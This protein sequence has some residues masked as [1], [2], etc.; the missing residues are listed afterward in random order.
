[1]KSAEDTAAITTTEPEVSTQSLDNARQRTNAPYNDRAWDGIKE[2]GDDDRALLRWFHLYALDNGLSNVQ[3]GEIVGYDRTNAYRILMGTY[4]GGRAW[5]KIV[6]A[7]RDYRVRALESISVPGIDK[8]PGF[9]LTS[10]ATVFWNGLDYASR[11]GF[12]LLAGPSGAGKSK[13]AVEWDL[14]N[15]GRAVRFNAP[16]TGAH[17]SLI[18]DLAHRIGLGAHSKVSTGTLMRGLLARVGRNQVLIVDQGSRLLPN[19]EQ[20]RATSLEILMELNE[21]TGCGVVIPLTWRSVESMAHMAYQIEQITGRAEI[22]RAPDPTP[23]DIT[24]IA[25]QYGTF[26]QRIKAALLDLSHKPGGL[27]TVSKVLSL[28]DRMARAVKSP[29]V[30][31]DHVRAAMEKRFENMGGIDPF[32]TKPKRR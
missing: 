10:A 19:A 6:Q 24:L 13:A 9:Q 30:T 7:I 4:Q 28:A 17:V 27:R 1:M 12:V 2:L 32:D 8:E 22:F 25:S 16:P 29:K 20:I 11:G 3:V 21:R 26:G 23:E 31:D 14:R 15:P 18:R 5:P